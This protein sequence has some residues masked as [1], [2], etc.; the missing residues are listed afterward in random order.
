MT[1]G[2]IR[3]AGALPVGSVG[4]HA[5]GWWG[6]IAVVVTEAGLFGYL[7]FSYYFTLTQLG[8]DAFLPGEAP[9]FR[10]AGPNTALLL[11]SSVAVGWGERGLRR[12]R[13]GQLVAGLVA[14]IALGALFAGIQLL[15]WSGKDFTL[16]SGVYGSL[17]FTIT[18]FHLAHVLVGLV[19]LALMALW[20][21]LGL[22]DRVRHAPVTIGALYWHFV[23]AV[24]LAVFF[25]LY[26]TPHWM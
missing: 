24:W 13:K 21:G 12:G 23:D 1:G 22:F 6:M 8:A 14:A 18:G 19:G 7:L 4:R 2:E 17:Y 11:A 3:R 10:L 16:T 26:V 20:T 15:E 9:S 25:T 5:S